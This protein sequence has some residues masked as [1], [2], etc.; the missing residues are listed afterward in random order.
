MPDELNDEAL[1]R[2]EA[3]AAKSRRGER[4]TRY[5]LLVLAVLLTGALVVA[6]WLAWNN[7]SLSVQNAATAASQEAAK[8]SLAEQVAAACA[9]DDF[10]NTT[11]GAQVCQRAAQVAKE[12]AAPI[13]GPQGAPGAPGQDGPPGADGAPGRDGTNGAPGKDGADG[14]P[15]KDGAD[16]VNGQDGLPGQPGATGAQGPQGVP[17]KDGTNGVDGARGPAGPAPS[18]IVWTWNGQ[19]FTCTPESAGST[20]YRCTSSPTTSTATPQIK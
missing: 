13:A 4:R 12:P 18:Q 8:R 17:G 11:Q 1:A 20:T 7:H 2:A 9:K 14:A 16:G 10:R 15:G 3:L 5:T 19:T 6:G